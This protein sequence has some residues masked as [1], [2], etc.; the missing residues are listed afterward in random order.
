MFIEK[1]K[2]IN[3]LVNQVIF[4]FRIRKHDR[5]RHGKSK[6]LT[7]DLKKIRPICPN[8]RVYFNGNGLSLRSLSKIRI[9]T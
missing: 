1:Q 5:H 3:S 6:A 4:N 9:I 7:K 8:E 2:I